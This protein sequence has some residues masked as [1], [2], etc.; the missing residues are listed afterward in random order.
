MDRGTSLGRDSTVRN[1][2]NVVRSFF[3]FFNVDRGTSLGTDSAV[4][5]QEVFLMGTLHY[6]WGIKRIIIDALSSDHSCIVVV[7]H[8]DWRGTVAICARR[9]GVVRVL[10]VHEVYI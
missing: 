6:W 9:A 8:G 5:H 4:R 2:G 1:Q 10:S 3:F 7:V